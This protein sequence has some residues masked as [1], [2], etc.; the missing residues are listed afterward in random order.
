[1]VEQ[2]PA[3]CPCDFLRRLALLGLVLR[4]RL[5]PAKVFAPDVVD[6]YRLL[7]VLDLVVAR[8]EQD[9]PV[10]RPEHLDVV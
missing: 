1:M 8:R 9:V 3:A 10:L 4:W 7:V 2:E 6:E 5:F